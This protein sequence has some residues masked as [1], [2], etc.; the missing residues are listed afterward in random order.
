MSGS[1]SRGFLSTEKLDSMNRKLTKQRSESLEEFLL[2]KEQSFG[3]EESSINQAPTPD[4]NF[5]KKEEEKYSP[6]PARK[7]MSLD[8][9]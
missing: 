2:D 8:Y 5:A 4:K 7:K 9:S 6:S 3:R 1:P